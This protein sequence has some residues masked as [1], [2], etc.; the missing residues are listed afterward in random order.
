M[1]ETQN[2]TNPV[3]D[4]IYREGCIN[5]L[6]CNYDSTANIDDGSCAFA[7]DICECSLD[8]GVVNGDAINGTLG[9]G[10]VFWYSFDV[11]AVYDN[12]LVSLC[13]SSFDST[14]Q[15][16]GT[17]TKGFTDLITLSDEDV[18]DSV[19]IINVKVQ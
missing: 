4:I 8:G 2:I 19:V 10:E 6:A 5:P 11:D 16:P 15:M 17:A 13:G 12:V 3:I 7:G 1:V 9:A 14:M 18:S